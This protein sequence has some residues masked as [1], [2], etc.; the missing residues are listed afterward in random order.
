[1]IDLGILNGSEE[2]IPPKAVGIDLPTV[3]VDSLI[4]M[5][6]DDVASQGL[7]RDV[8]FI[9]NG[10][11]SL[12]NLVE[13]ISSNIGEMQAMYLSS[14]AFTEVPT[15]VIGELKNKFPEMDLFII[16]DVRA[17]ANYE[18]VFQ[19]LRI[20]TPHIAIVPCHAKITILQGSNKTISI[21][22]SANWTTNKRIEV[23]W[24]SHIQELADINK[25]FIQTQIKKFLEKNGPDESRKI[26]LD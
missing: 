7:D 10:E 8:F 2:E 19:Q 25:I 4:N 24:I 21:I 14:F 6:V 1:M 5:S 3:E 18:G 13:K 26:N 22:G 12:H 11:F 9:T 15:R 23:G 17:K 16:A 20:M